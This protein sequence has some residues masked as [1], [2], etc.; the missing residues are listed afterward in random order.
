MKLYTNFNDMLFLKGYGTPD[1]MN[2]EQSSIQYTKF[3]IVAKL[4]LV[5]PCVTMKIYIN[6]MIIKN[7][8]LVIYNKEIS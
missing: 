4:N 5:Y 8:H 1:V 2:T 6:V 3:E 7:K